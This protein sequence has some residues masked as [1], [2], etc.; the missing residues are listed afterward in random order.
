MIELRWVEIEKCEGAYVRV[1]GSRP[2]KLQ[3]REWPAIS[4]AGY[5]EPPNVE[6]NWKDVPIEHI[7]APPTAIAMDDIVRSLS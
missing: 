1:G 2:H 3:Y 4:D 5:I 7:P 6:P